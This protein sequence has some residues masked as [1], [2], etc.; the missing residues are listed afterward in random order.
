MI[1][2]FL[3]QSLCQRG[4]WNRCCRISCSG[5]LLE[6]EEPSL[7]S[8]GWR[9]LKPKPKQTAHVSLAAASGFCMGNVAET[10]ALDEKGW[11]SWLHRC[12]PGWKSI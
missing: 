7:P 3:V 1:P 8:A 12:L 6:A 5:E 9:T 11:C 2:A 10:M 4:A